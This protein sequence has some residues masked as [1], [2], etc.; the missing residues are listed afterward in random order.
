MQVVGL[1]GLVILHQ[2]EAQPLRHA[3][4]DLAFHLGQVE[5]PADIVGGAY[6][7]HLYRA[8]LDIDF[9]L[10]HLRGKGIGCVRHAL[11]VLVQRDGRR[12]KRALAGEDVAA[13]VAGQLGQLDAMFTRAVA[14][15]EFAMFQAKFGVGFGLHQREHARAQLL[16]GKA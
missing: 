15:D 7:Q 13:L 2:R 11:P 6:A 10:G 3:A 1:A 5:C 4:V 12:I 8:Q 16:A 9:H 14:G